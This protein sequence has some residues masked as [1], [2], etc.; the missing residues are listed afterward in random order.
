MTKDEIFHLEYR[1]YYMYSAVIND[2]HL[3]RE[4]GLV[5]HYFQKI[6]EELRKSFLNELDNKY[7]NVYC[8]FSFGKDRYDAYFQQITEDG[9]TIYYDLLLPKISKIY[10]TFEPRVKFI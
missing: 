3:S 1:T 7:K 10:R 4:N 2:V 9:D 6:L 8:V 5:A